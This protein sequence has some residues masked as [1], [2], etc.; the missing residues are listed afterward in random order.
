MKK[1]TLLIFSA[2]AFVLLSS[3]SIDVESKN[4]YVTVY[5][6]KYMTESLF[7]DTDLTVGIVPGVTSHEHSAEWSP[8]QIIAMKDADYLFYIG[9]NYDQ[10]VDKK[11][12]VFESADV[13]LIKIEDQSDYIQYI[14]GVSHTHEHTDHDHEDEITTRESELGLDPHFWVSPKRMLDVL[15]LLYDTYIDEYTDYNDEITSNYQ[16]LKANLEELH[17][18]YQE[19]I[20]AMNKPALTSTNL[21]G[22]LKADYG[23][24]YISISPGYHEEPDNMIA[25]EHAELMHE[26]EIHNIN[27]IIYE[28]KRTS[29]AS[30]Y[31]FSEMAKLDIEPVKLQ[32][33][34]LQALSDDDISK[35][36]GYISV[37]REN[38]DVF[39]EAG[40]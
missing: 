33:D 12:N 40:K 38:L 2:I 29:P 31:I 4:V 26:I 7:T 8:K 20:S 10:Y 24:S 5:P 25:D 39:S 15:E 18:D 6:L 3:C 21:Y 13:Q 35:G 34:V 28:K 9:A 37:M 32:F 17:I 36:K 1:I 30:D 23:F 16:T 14:E 11:L 19:T 22:Y 27:K